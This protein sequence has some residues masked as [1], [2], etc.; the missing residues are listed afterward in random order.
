MKVLSWN[1]PGVNEEITKILSQDSLYP[2]EH[3]PNKNLEQINLFDLIFLVFS[4]LCH[5]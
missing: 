1:L 3:L 5:L 4:I 2:T